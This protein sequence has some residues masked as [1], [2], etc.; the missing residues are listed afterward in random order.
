MKERNK[1]NNQRIEQNNNE[2]LNG[3]TNENERR[4]KNDYYIY[5]KRVII[6][7]FKRKNRSKKNDNGNE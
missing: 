7:N 6:G 4:N 2:Y 3:F 5:E 1:R